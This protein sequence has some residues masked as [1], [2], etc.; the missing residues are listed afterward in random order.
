MGTALQGWARYQGALRVGSPS[1]AR[2]TRPE[3]SEVIARLNGGAGDIDTDGEVDCLVRVANHM[4][5]HPDVQTTSAMAD[6]RRYIADRHLDVAT[7]LPRRT[8]ANTLLRDVALTY[9]TPLEGV[10]LRGIDRDDGT[11]SVGVRP[12]LI[13]TIASGAVRSML[14]NVARRVEA[15][16]SAVSGSAT[17]RVRGIYEVYDPTDATHII[18]YAFWSTARNATD[19]LSFGRVTVVAPNGRTVATLTESTTASIDL[20]RASDDRDPGTP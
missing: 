16:R 20:F 9:V 10:N 5:L 14:G 2:V 13:Q 15:T 7:H 17:Y 12:C 6:M 18:G 3:L 1:N 8:V 19:T 11:Q 4:R